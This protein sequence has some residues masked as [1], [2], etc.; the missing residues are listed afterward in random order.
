MS[1]LH[2]L[3]YGSNL[4]P[5]RLGERVASARLLGWL[6]L[7]GCRLAFHTV[8]GDG[9]GKC[10]LE[11]TG[12]AADTAYAALY[13][14]EASEKPALDAVEGPPYGV[15]NWQVTLSGQAYSAFV[16][17]ARPEAV[18]PQRV[19]YAWYRDVVWR[20]AHYLGLPAEYVSAI[21]RVPAEQDPDEERRHSHRALLE[22]MAGA[23]EPA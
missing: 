19:P 1:K 8:G 9:S 11:V 16:Y 15:E 5:V 4:H 7:P 20:G 18:D 21:A 14:L 3:A 17:L 23:E 10:D 2:Y 12:E 22:R 6:S 13:E